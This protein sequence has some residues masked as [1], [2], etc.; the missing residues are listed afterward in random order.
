METQGQE[1]RG[2]AARLRSMVLEVVRRSGCGHVATSFS[3]AEIIVALYYGGGLR[4]DPADPGWPGRDRLLLSKGHAS[5]IL[6]C[7]LADLGFFPVEELWRTGREDGRMG[8]HLQTDLPGIEATSGSLGQGLGLGCGLALAARRRSESHLVYV[9]TGDA[10]L[11]EGSVWEGFLFAAHHRLNNLIVIIDRNHMGCADFTENCLA[12]EPLDR[13]LEAF[14]LKVI[15]ADGHDPIALASEL[16]RL[17][18]RPWP[19]PV[20]LIA[21]TVKGRGLARVENAPRCH[22]YKPQGEDLDR[23]LLEVKGGLKP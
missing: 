13:K 3:C 23:D 12:L 1:L 19:G 21:D 9:I 22:H 7:A 16:A 2:Q 6:Y 15:K 11:N 20:A 10:E 17:R 14:G 18:A 8:V 5:T 4:F